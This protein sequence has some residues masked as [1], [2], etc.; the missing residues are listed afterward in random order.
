MLLALSIKLEQPIIRF[1]LSSVLILNL[2]IMIKIIYGG[3]YL[4][5]QSDT[6]LVKI[7]MR[8]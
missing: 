6:Q 7:G 4:N 2:I 5:G 1:E 3:Y 8:V